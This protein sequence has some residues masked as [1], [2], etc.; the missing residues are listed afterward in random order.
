MMQPDTSGL[1]ADPS[2]YFYAFEGDDALFVEMDRASYARSLFLDRRIVAKSEGVA[3][4]PL[5]QLLQARST[6]QQAEL[7]WIFHVAHCGSTLLANA[8][9]QG[10]ANLVLR[11]PRP[12]RQLAVSAVSQAGIPPPELLDL[13]TAMLARRF[14]DTKSVIVKANVPVNFIIPDLMSRTPLSPAIF[15]HFALEDYLYAILRT[16][17]HRRWVANVTR[18]LLPAIEAKSGSLAGLDVAKRGAALWLAQMCQYA[19]ALVRYPN[20]RS[21]DAELLFN[22]PRLAVAAA[23]FSVPIGSLLDV[24]V[25]NAVYQSPS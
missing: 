2:S 11:E 14:Q 24:A 18:D 19:E 6:K 12:L 23:A 17:N 25:A 8:L 5:T 3:K 16:P 20:A 4:L 9:E 13:A 1:F 10:D 15:L 21:L 22:E 7:G